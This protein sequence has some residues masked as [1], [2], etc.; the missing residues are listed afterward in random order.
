MPSDHLSL[1]LFAFF[2]ALIVGVAER[3]NLVA[4][5]QCVCLAHIADVAKRDHQRVRQAG[6]GVS[7]NMGL[8]S[9]VPVIAL[10]VVHPFQSPIQIRRSARRA[11]F[12]QADS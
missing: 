8:E 2:H 9:E 5:Q 4:V 3:A 12:A 11:I 1:I 10:L 7:A 6:R